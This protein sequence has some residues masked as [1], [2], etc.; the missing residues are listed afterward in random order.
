MSGFVGR[1][2]ICPS[3][4]A[5]G[6]QGYETHAQ[7]FCHGASPSNGRQPGYRLNAKMAVSN[8]RAI[9]ARLCDE[10][11]VFHLVEMIAGD[12]GMPQNFIGEQRRWGTRLGVVSW[13]A[14]RTKRF[15]RA[16]QIAEVA[17]GH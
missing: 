17:L 6:R 11:G 16:I 15:H 14:I 4:E 9:I 10:I 8:S 1:V 12:A 2:A 13:T 3:P 5:A 7:H